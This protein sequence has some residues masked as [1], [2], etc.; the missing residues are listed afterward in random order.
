VGLVFGSSEEVERIEAYHHEDPP[1][2]F[3][4]PLFARRGLFASTD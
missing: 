3:N 1:E 2:T 4:S